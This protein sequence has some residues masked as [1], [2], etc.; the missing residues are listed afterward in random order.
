MKPKVK[1]N[2]KK[3]IENIPSKFKVVKQIIQGNKNNN[4][5]SKIINKIATR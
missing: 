1:I 5:K 2:K 3:I 4:S